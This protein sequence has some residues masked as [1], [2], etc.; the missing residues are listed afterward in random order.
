M[1]NYKNKTILF[2]G[3]IVII[4][5]FALFKKDINY[6]FH[7]TFIN[8]KNMTKQSQYIVQYVGFKTN[9]TENDFIQRW[10]PFA[11]NFKRAGIKT[12]DLYKISDSD[13]FTFISRNIWDAKTYFQ[14]FPTGMAGSGSG[15]GISVTQLGGYW[16][17]ENQLAKPNNMQLL[18]TNDN[19][20]STFISRKRC[21]EKVRFENQ[22]ELGE[23]DSTIM[24]EY[25]SN[26]LNC[27]HLKTM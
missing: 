17:D 8:P 1:S 4:G 18:F 19:F 23:K 22:I 27:T 3:L 20:P 5:S 10:I 12:I 16:I 9:L 25:L 14:N 24:N 11:T 7:K 6:L 26:M 2:L 13:Q 21:T 15:G